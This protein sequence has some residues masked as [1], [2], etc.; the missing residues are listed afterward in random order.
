ML[1]RLRKSLKE[2][3]VKCNFNSKQQDTLRSIVSY[4]LQN[5]DITL[6]DLY[7]H[8]PFTS[9]DYLKIF[10]GETAPVYDLI[11]T[12]HHVVCLA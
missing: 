6:Q 3:F 5:G 8:K 7:T 4:L 9:M 12:L 10:N 2:Y 11:N 1:K